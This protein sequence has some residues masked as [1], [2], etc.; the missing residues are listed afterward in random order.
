MPGIE[1]ILNSQVIFWIKSAVDIVAVA[2]LF[3]FLYKLFE[4]TNSISIVKGFILVIAIYAIANFVGLKT[5]AWIFKYVVGYF[6]ILVVVLFQPEIRRVL[7][8][9]GQS[10]LAGVLVK[11]SKETLAEITEAAWLLSEKRLGGLIIIER[12]V[13]LKHLLDESVQLDAA[14]K[15]ELLLSIFYKGT[16]LH[17]GAVLIEGEKIAGARIIIPSVR[18]DAVLD[19]KSGLGT[20]HRAGIAVTIDTDAVSVI[21]SEETGHISI[22]Y[23]G[24]LEYNLGFEVFVRRLNEIMGLE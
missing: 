21:V 15:S 14:V 17:D 1:A 18:I 8:R 4:D 7:S 24:K 6:V 11:L 23:N 3:Y 19:R 16:V 9:M 5:L 12:K 22:A 10:G 20:R 13:G 2:Y